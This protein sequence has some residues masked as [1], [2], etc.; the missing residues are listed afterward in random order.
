MS[1]FR[2]R[3]AGDIV[4]DFL[5]SEQ[6]SSDVLIICDGLPSGS[7][8]DALVKWFSRQGFW[9]FHL[10]YRGTWESGE[11]FLDHSPEQDLLDLIKALSDGV[12]DIWSH[13]TFQ[14]TPKRVGIVG[15]SFGGTAA[16]MA[17][18]S[19]LVHRVIAL[20]PVVD[21]TAESDEPMDVLEDIVRRGY[22][23]AYRF[24]H[25]DWLKLSRGDFFQPMACVKT[26]DP[27]KIFV[28]HAQ[29]DRVVPIDPI[30]TFVEHVGCPHRFY[31]TGGH[32]LWQKVMHWP[33]R[34]RLVSF[35]RS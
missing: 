6:D 8:K 15:A 26:F 31:K 9:T 35:L 25:E 22:M 17:S 33:M 24:S 2:A 23:G 20:S 29:D 34:A 11:N 10:R 27:H 12:S 3:V 30:R 21:W 14:V 7:S 13:Q 32:H 28:A 19:T 18:R 16:L 1:L 5:P 4:V